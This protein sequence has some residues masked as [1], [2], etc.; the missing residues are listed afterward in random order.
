M[1]V[2]TGQTIGKHVV[3]VGAGGNI[4]SHLVPSLAR[5]TAVACITL[6]DRDIYEEANLRSQN[7]TARDLDKAK[8]TV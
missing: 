4:G 6:I 8:A 7:I 5:L 3:V 1:Q 2:T